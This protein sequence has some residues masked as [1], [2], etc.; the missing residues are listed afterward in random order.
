MKDFKVLFFNKSIQETAGEK[1][2]IDNEKINLIEKEGYEVLIVWESEYH[3][4]HKET[5]QKCINFI[6]G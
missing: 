6:R 3:Q 2:K 5:I 1:W 4:N